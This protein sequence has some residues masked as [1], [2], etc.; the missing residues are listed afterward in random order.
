MIDQKGSANERSRH[1]RGTPS[2]IWHLS[3][4]PI[5]CHLP[6]FLVFSVY[7]LGPCFVNRMKKSTSI[8]HDFEIFYRPRPLRDAA[9]AYIIETIKAGEVFFHGGVRRDR[10][11]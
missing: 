11:V 7:A 6:V 8:L 3:P 2:L 5:V 1:D 4:S 10:G 9:R